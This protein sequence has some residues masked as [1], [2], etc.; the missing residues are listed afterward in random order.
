[1]IKDQ[2]VELVLEY[3]TNLLFRQASKELRVV[4]HLELGRV[5]VDPNS[6]SLNI[7][8]STLLYFSTESRKEGLIHQ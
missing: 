1:M 7:V 5:W 3:T 4:D 2:V 6:G 8:I